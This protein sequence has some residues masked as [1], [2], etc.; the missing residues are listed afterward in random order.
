MDVQSILG[1]QVGKC[2]LLYNVLTMRLLAPVSSTNAQKKPYSMCS[3]H[4]PVVWAWR[5]EKDL[6]TAKNEMVDSVFYQPFFLLLLVSHLTFPSSPGLI[7]LHS[8]LTTGCSR[9]PLQLCSHLRIWLYK[10]V[11]SCTNCG[12]TVRYSKLDLMIA[13]VQRLLL[14]FINT[15]SATTAGPDVPNPLIG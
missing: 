9:L 5:T 7:R 13:R 15:E 2:L 6:S 3:V 1:T 12:F 11:L 8:Y 10:K 4:D 14:L